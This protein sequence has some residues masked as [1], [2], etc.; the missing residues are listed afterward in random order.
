MSVFRLYEPHEL[1]ETG[2]PFAWRQINSLTVMRDEL[3]EV[4]DR[5]SQAR[6]I[7]IK[8]LV[9]QDAGDRCVRCGHPYRVGQDG[10]MEPASLEGASLAA[11]LGIDPR[12]LDLG[13]ELEADRR[14][15]ALDDLIVKA[16]RTHWSPCDEQCTH[17]GPCR[18][19]RF[20]AID[21][22]PWS[23]L[24]F[25]DPYPTA[26]VWSAYNSSVQ[27]AWRILT[28]H[29]LNGVKHDCRWWNLTALCQRCHLEIQGKV[30]M[31]RVFPLEHSEWFKPY[32]AGW[33]AFIYLGED[34]TREQAVER[35]DELL[36]LEQMA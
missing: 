19:K 21:S 12:A 4:V 3:D 22:S 11:D 13:F 28:V 15:D 23:E 17:A 32:A 36:A 31:E 27:A 33:Y 34:L 18:A 2:Y 25:T 6:A 26:G 35:Q 5:L 7:G 9:R 20:P 29:H 16:K 10:I 14:G 30:T 24:R 1:A 8:D